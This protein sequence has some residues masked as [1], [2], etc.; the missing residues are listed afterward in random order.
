MVLVQKSGQVSFT[1]VNV[2]PALM[3]SA[4]AVICGVFLTYG[5]YLASMDNGLVLHLSGRKSATPF[6]L[7]PEE[8]RSIGHLVRYG[9][10]SRSG[11]DERR[12]GL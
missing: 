11:N 10:D 1:E 6:A 5:A 12:K 9:H 7:L 2:V 4:G 8:A 3:W